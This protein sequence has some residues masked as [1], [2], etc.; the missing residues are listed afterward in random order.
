MPSRVRGPFSNYYTIHYTIKF[1][2]CMLSTG[3]EFKPNPFNTTEAI[4]AR[5]Y[6]LV[7]LIE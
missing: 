6:F 4:Y 3:Q 5:D 7:K 1:M 2:H